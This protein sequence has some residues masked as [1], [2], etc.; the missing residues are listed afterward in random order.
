MPI[1]ANT[2][3]TPFTVDTVPGTRTDYPIRVAK[4]G[5]YVLEVDGASTLVG[6][7]DHKLVGLL[8]VCGSGVKGT[9]A[10]TP[11]GNLFIEVDGKEGGQ[12]T[13]NLRP[14]VFSDYLW[15]N[16]IYTRYKSTC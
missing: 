11:A 9:H 14:W 8:R 7:R 16:F 15:S 4:G 2:A 10:N 5:R 1:A 6:L 13:I 12:V 3:G